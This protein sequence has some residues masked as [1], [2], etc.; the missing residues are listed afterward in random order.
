M[1]W[2]SLSLSDIK[3]LENWNVSIGND[4]GN[5]FCR[6]SSLLD[7]KPLENWNEQMEIILNF[8][9]MDAHHYQI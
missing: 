8:Y 2:G 6:C 1:F 4:F 9:F 3:P 5:I 7:I